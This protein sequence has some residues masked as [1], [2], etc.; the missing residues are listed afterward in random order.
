MKIDGACHCGKITYEAEV[1]PEGSRVCHCTDCQK[2]GGTAFRMVVPSVP[3][4][5][6]L[7]GGAPKIYYKIAESGNKRIQGFCGDCGTHIYATT[8]AEDPKVYNIR[9]GTITQH[10]QLPPKTQIWHRSAQAWLPALDDL[11]IVEKQQ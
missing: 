1:D 2:I 7:T 11:R 5:F 8:I 6:T 3:G 10:D 9:T 4:G